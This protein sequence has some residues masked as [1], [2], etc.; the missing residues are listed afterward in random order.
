MTSSFQSNFP[1][2]SPEHLDMYS[3]TVEN[4]P[5]HLFLPK[6]SRPHRIDDLDHY[7]D[8]LLRRCD[9]LL[10]SYDNDILQAGTSKPISQD[11]H[12]IKEQ[13]GSRKSYDTSSSSSSS[14]SLLSSYP[15]SVST[16]PPIKTVDQIDVE[17]SDMPTLDDIVKDL[18]PQ[19]SFQPLRGN[20]SSPT[21]DSHDSNNTNERL[22]MYLS[23]SSSVAV[24]LQN[25]VSPQPCLDTQEYSAD[26]AYSQ[27]I[28]TELLPVVTP[29]RLTDD[30]VCD[31]LDD[32][33]VKTLWNRLL[34]VRQKLR[35]L[36]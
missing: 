2:Q 32:E 21:R 4:I 22:L 20:C 30:E 25:E 1:P 35:S 33:V 10:N 23:P 36:S 6:E 15:P 31:Y 9:H 29:H 13:D 19:E 7:A 27:V 24:S 26:L 3:T 17:D 5:Q 14:F 34:H 16:L 28:D 12:N 11:Q 18:I 8:E